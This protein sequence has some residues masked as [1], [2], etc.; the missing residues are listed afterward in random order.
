MRL[1]ESS[2]VEPTAINSNT[3]HRVSIGCNNN[4]NNINNNEAQSRKAYRTIRQDHCSKK[5]R[6][7]CFQALAPACRAVAP[8]WS[9]ALMSAPECSRGCVTLAFMPHETK[10]GEC[11][12]VCVCVRARVCVCVCAC[13][14]ACVSLCLP[15]L[16]LMFS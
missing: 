4:N 9:W 2:P 13:V 12:C 8:S 6:S 5:R 10:W 16:K 11:V 14:R 15:D 7:C 1:R 3:T